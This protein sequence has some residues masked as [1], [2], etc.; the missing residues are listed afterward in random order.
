M[1]TAVFRAIV[2]FV[3]IPKP[4][5]FLVGEYRLNRFAFQDRISGRKDFAIVSRFSAEV[6]QGQVAYG[7][8]LA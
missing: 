1:G 2:M 4:F 5:G 8:R 3:S 7:R 6:N